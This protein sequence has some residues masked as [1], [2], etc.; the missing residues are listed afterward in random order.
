MSRSRYTSASAE[1]YK[2]LARR[3]S[4]PADHLQDRDF[5]FT[6]EAIHTGKRDVLR[7]WSGLLHLYLPD[8][9]SSY[10]HERAAV[11]GVGDRVP[12]RIDI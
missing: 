2:A 7:A 1:P 5:V 10:Q 9:P 6:D 4:V 8:V 11:L 12:D 3:D